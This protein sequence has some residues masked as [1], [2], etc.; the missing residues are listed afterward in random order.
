MY[1]PVVRFV[2]CPPQRLS[3]GAVIQSL[4]ESALTMNVEFPTVAA[5]VPVAANVAQVPL[6][7]TSSF[8][9]HWKNEPRR[10]RIP[11]AQSERF[12]EQIGMLTP[13]QVQAFNAPTL[14]ADHACPFESTISSVSHPAYLGIPDVPP[15]TSASA[16]PPFGSLTSPLAEFGIAE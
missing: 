11:A 12:P 14:H 1:V 7:V 15:S 13:V 5:R 2:V 8:R 4:G 16:G 10:F 6:A 9:P 3:F